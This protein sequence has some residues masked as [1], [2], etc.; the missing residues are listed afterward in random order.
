MD[1]RNLIAVGDQLVWRIMNHTPDDPPLAVV[2]D[3]TRRFATY[4]TQ[5]GDIKRG[6]VRQRGNLIYTKDPTCSCSKWV[7]TGA[8]AYN[9]YH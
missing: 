1:A 3:V 8:L 4:Q 7:K 9:T 2:I 5:N 6:M